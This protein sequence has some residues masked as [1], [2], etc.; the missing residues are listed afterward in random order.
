[1]PVLLASFYFV[2]LGSSEKVK[3]EIYK[4]KKW[5]GFTQIKSQVKSLWLLFCRAVRKLQSATTHVHVGY[6]AILNISQIFVPCWCF[7]LR[8]FIFNSQYPNMHERV[9]KSMQ[10]AKVVAFLVI[11]LS[12][13]KINRKCT[14]C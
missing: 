11:F 12:P 14:Y 8:N 7:F 13:S 3:T 10:S 1:M 9:H 4:L 2:T 5:H 6:V